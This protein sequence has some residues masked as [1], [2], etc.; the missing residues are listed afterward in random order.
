MRRFLSG[1]FFLCSFASTGIAAEAPVLMVFGDSLSAGYGIAPQQA[2]PRLLET[3][4]AKRKPAWRVVNA[5]VSGETSAGGLSRIDDALAQHRPRMVIVE[6]GAN[7]GLRGLPITEMEANLAEIIRTIQKSGASVHLVGMRIPPNYGFD[8]T[9]KFAA[10][11]EK[12]AKQYKTGLTPFLLS[13]IILKRARYFQGD[14]L[15]PTAEAQP[16]LMEEVLGDLKL[17]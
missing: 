11:F 3:E 17:K 5:S 10:S 4:L 6:L 7:D 16:L 1:L 9:K 12:L 2:W 8:Y 13:P 14:G 15:H